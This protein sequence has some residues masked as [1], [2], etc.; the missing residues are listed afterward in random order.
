MNVLWVISWVYNDI[1]GFHDDSV[2]EECKVVQ[3]FVG[4]YFERCAKMRH[5][6]SHSYF[7]QVRDFVLATR[8]LCKI[9]DLI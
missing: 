1:I 3:E 8:P 5:E 7:V 9:G 2:E 6:P 4:F